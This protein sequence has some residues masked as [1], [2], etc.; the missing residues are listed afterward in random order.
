[1]GAAVQDDA[2]LSAG[3]GDNDIEY[4][5]MN[6]YSKMK[7]LENKYID[8]ANFYKQELVKS[9]STQRVGESD[10][11]SHRFPS[12]PNHRSNQPDMMDQSVSVIDV[13]IFSLEKN[14][15]EEQLAVVLKKSY[16]Q[17]VKSSM[18]SLRK[19]KR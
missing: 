17:S 16:L 12:S 8:L 1:M 3:G 10:N 5:I 2:S 11:L 15:P 13:N 19:R 7:N 18:T 4:I 14:H 9:S 6:L